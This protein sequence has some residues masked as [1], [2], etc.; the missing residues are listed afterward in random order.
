MRWRAS[1]APPLVAITSYSSSTVAVR[2]RE[3]TSK[4]TSI[5]RVTSRPSGPFSTTRRAITPANRFRLVLESTPPIEPHTMR[6]TPALRPSRAA[7]SREIRPSWETVICP[8]MAS[9]PTMRVKCAAGGVR[10]RASSSRHP[11][12]TSP[13]SAEFPDEVRKGTKATRVS[14]FS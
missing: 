12:V 8:S 11:A 1:V 2:T 13:P 4:G 9:F 14:A 3:T 10:R 6:S 5:Q 7:S